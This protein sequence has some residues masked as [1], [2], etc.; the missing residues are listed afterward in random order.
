M[1]ITIKLPRGSPNYAVQYIM[2][3]LRRFKEEGWIDTFKLTK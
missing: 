3:W 1:T 2:S